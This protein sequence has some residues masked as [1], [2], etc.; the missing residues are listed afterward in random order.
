MRGDFSTGSRTTTK[1]AIPSLTTNNETIAIANGDTNLSYIYFKEKEECTPS[2]S[3]LNT[4]ERIFNCQIIPRTIDIIEKS[5]SFF[6]LIQYHGV[7][8]DHSEYFDCARILLSSIDDLVKTDITDI[9]VLDTLRQSR[10]QHIILVDRHV[11]IQILSFIIKE[12]HKFTKLMS[13]QS[14][15]NKEDFNR[16]DQHIIDKLERSRK[17]LTELMFNT[18][19]IEIQQELPVYSNNMHANQQPL[20]YY[21]STEERMVDFQQLVGRYEINH[22]FATKLRMLEGY[23]IVFICDDSGSMNTPLSDFAGVSNKRLTRW[24]ELKQTVSIVVDLASVFDPDGVDIY[25]LNREPVFHVRNSEQL[26]SVFAIPPSG[27]TPIVSVF[28]RLLRDKQ[29]EIEERKLLIL[30]AT[31]GVPTDDQG[32]RDIRSLKHVLKR[33]RKPTNHIPVTIIACT[34]DDDCMAYLND[35]DKKIPNLDVVDD[36]RNEKKEIQAL[37]G[38]D[39]PFSF[40][41]YVVKILMGGVDSWFDDLDEKKVSTDGYGRPKKDYGRKRKKRRCVIL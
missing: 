5:S 41:D 10:I 38:K 19:R 33:E 36:Y 4:S 23:E 37:Q 20:D 29:H 35:W 2:D 11:L 25:F 7:S 28:R 6:D 26:V 16:S 15:L 9:V 1:H 18:V 21:R 27:P 8:P 32:N 13:L 17:R 12:P 24:D 14:M 22:T 34:D 39:F 31:D 30:L 3:Q 40:G